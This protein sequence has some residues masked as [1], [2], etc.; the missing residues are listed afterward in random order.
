[1]RLTCILFTVATLTAQVIPSISQFQD[2]TAK[3]PALIAAEYRLRAAQILRDRYPEQSRKLL[4]EAVTSL[5]D[6][7]IAPT[8]SIGRLMKE[9]A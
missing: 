9:L 4:A 7:P 8:S 2:A 6:R 5:K 3:V 1:M